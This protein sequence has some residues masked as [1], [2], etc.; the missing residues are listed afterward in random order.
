MPLT[1]AGP[2]VNWLTSPVNSPGPRTD[3]GLRR[4]AGFVHDLDLA[5]LDDEELEVAVAGLEELLPV[6]VPL[7]RRQGAAPQRGHL[8]LVELGEGDG[9]QVVLGHVSDSS[10]LRRPMSAHRRYGSASRRHVSSA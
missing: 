3:D 10:G 2:P 7:E 9:V 1:I 8:G 5:G 4:L 6:P